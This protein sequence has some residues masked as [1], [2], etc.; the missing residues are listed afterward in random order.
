MGQRK[1]RQLPSM[2]SRETGHFI[3][4]PR[5]MLRAEIVEKI[6]AGTIQWN[7]KLKN[8][9]CWSDDNGRDDDHN[10]S[11]VTV[12]LTD[13]TTIDAGLLIGADGIFSTVRRQLGLPGDRLN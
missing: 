4:I 9:S 8:F 3:H 11:G 1:A 10:R 2:H 6:R 13:G 5:Q 7:S 12:T